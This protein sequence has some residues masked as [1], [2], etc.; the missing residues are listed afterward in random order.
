MSDIFISYSS[1][2]RK[3]VQALAQALERKGWSV[4]WDRR[5]R[6]GGAFDEIIQKALGAAKSVVV[7]WTEFSIKSTWVKNEARKGMKRGVLFPVMMLQE[8]EIPLE[9]EHLQA[10]QLMDWQPDQDHPGFD[11]FIDDLAGVIGAPVTQSQGTPASSAKPTPEPETGSLQGAVRAVLLSGNNNLS[12]L[13]LSQGT[14]EP[15][16]A[17]STT[18]YKVNVASDVSS[19]NISATKADSDAVLSEHVTAGAGTATGQTTLP[20]N[21]PGTTTLASIT[22]TARNGSAKTYLI[23]VSRAALP[24]S[25][26]TG[27]GQSTE[28]LPYVPI[29]IGLLAAIGALVY[30]V[31]FSQGPSPQYQPA[32]QAPMVLVPAGEFTMGAREDDKSAGEGKR[33][34]HLVYLDAFYIDQYEVTTS[35]YATFFQETK[36]S[37]PE[38]WSEQVL[39]QH[40][41]KPVV[42]VDWHDATS[43]CTWGGKRL[44][45]EAEWEKAARGTDQRSFPWGNARPN[46]EPANY[47]NWRD[48]F[49]DYGVLTDVGSY[50][51]GK[52]PYGVYDMAGNVWEW[53]ADWYDMNYYAKSP[54]RNPKGPSTGEYQVA[55]GGSWHD[56]PV[57]VASAYRQS[58][59]PTERRATLGFR[60]ARDVPK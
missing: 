20:L 46:E 60:C 3:R 54:E 30:L 16:F 58:F 56:F 48:G 9:F 55:R 57:H 31:P 52:S 21:R 28:S 12:A 51:Q 50:E 8:V 11:Q 7:V 29:G 45:T 18:D 17:A 14:L 2:D 24:S 27:T 6:T 33:P 41:N 19:V 37:A 13:I 1:E 43:Y 39:K 26:S 15:A 22:V 10:A 47:L 25:Q 40:G 35:R 4:W 5:I 42:G 36:R 59:I 32:V 44:P 53:V 23:A 49:K 34:A 38:Y